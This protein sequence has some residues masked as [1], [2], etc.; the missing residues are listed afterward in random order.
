MSAA[1]WHAQGM[2]MSAQAVKTGRDAGL[3][4]H[5]G[6]LPGTDLDGEQF[7]VTTM[8]QAIEHVPSPT[9]TLTA[10]N[11]ILKPDRKS[12]V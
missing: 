6:T 2:D 5:Q 11:G 3:T 12:V 9:A 4:I 8:W 10:I 7:D 1:G